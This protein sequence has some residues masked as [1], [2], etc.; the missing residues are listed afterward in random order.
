MTD[1]IDFAVM[2]PPFGDHATPDAFRQLATTAEDAGF[3]A[4]WFADH[5]TFPS[6]IPDEY[7]FS[8]D[9]RSP[10]TSTDATYDTFQVL[11]HVAALTETVTIGTNV[12]IVPYRHPVTLTKHALT[13]DALSD[14]RFEFGVAAGWMK[15]EFEILDV[16]YE[17]RGSLTDEFLEL[18]HRACDEGEFAFNG[19]HHQFQR[20]G[21]Y[22]RPSDG[23]PPIWV[24]GDSP[25]VYRRIAEYGDGWTILWKRPEEV[26]ETKGEIQKRWDA[27]G[28]DGEPEVALMRPVEIDTTVDADESRPLVGSADEVIA[29]V[30]QYAEAGTTR[31]VMD[32]FT[33]DLDE[34][35]D[36]VK[37]VGR[38]VLPSF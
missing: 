19:E 11:S 36:Q 12:C 16:P 31:L 21:F 13:I 27:Y 28:R 20:T 7:P 17:H 32:F 9:G 15:T 5:V 4:V 18:F 30:E 10:F 25:P 23:R 29:D 1:D 24:G 14:G 2:L 34:Q 3:D 33:R 37:R 35:L 6:D 22:P 26:R 38:G 8:S